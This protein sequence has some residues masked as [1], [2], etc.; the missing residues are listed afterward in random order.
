MYQNFL[1]LGDF[2][3]SINEKCL[4]E[5]YN[6]NGLTSLIKNPACFKNPDK[7]TCIYLILTNQSSCFQHS[8]VFETGLPNF[9]LLKDIESKMSFQKRI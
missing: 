9:H 1:F 8:K 7:P 2:N 4:A 3:A 6:L 5:F